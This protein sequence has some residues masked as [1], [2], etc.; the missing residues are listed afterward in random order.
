MDVTELKKY[1]TKLYTDLYTGVI[2]D[3][4]PVQDGVYLE[5]LIQYAGKDLMTTQYQYSVE[6]LIDLYEK[7]MEIFRG[8]TLSAGFAR[9]TSA[10]MFQ[11]SI[12]NVMGSCGM[13]QH[14]ETYIMEDYEYDTLIMNPHEFLFEKGSPRYNMAFD[15]DPLMRVINFAKYVLAASDQSKTFAAAGKYIVE[16]YGL[17]SPPTGSCVNQWVPFDFIADSLRGFKNT[18]FDIRRCPDKVLQAMEALMPY[19]IWAGQNNV[20][21]PLGHN[22]IMTHMPTF[23]KTK[24]FE[25]FYWPTFNKICHI[26]AERGQAMSIFCEDDWTRYIDYLEELPQGTRL[27]M[28]Y[29]NPQLFK[30]RLGKKFILS[31]FYPITHLKTE[32]K[33][34]C[35][36]KAKELIDILAPGGNYYFSFDKSALMLS[37]INPENY[38]AVLEYAVEN[39]KYSNAGQLVTTA[40]KEDSIQNFSHLYPEFKSKYIQSY[41][42]F[43]SDYPLTDEKVGVYLKGIYDKYTRQVS[44][45][46]PN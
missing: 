28:E 7:G 19:L 24:D 33:Q 41:D 15:T 12:R 11:K 31:G 8:D 38:V 9:N 22:M 32:T 30:D 14:P 27:Y 45:L 5:Y 25:K 18:T 36:D 42:D 3:R 43:I 17:F 34:S 44:A 23:L 37:D 1:R 16:K 4:F 29:G 26:C 2:P 6:K 40:K 35:I 39:G 46:I 21:T 20:T 13:I 10:M